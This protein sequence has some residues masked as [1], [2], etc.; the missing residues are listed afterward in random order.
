MKRKIKTSP[1]KRF[2]IGMG[3][4]AVVTFIT[5]TIAYFSSSHTFNNK[6]SSN[7]SVET[8]NL[9]DKDAAMNVWPG[10]T[11]DSNLIVKNTGD[12]PIFVRIKYQ[13]SNKLNDKGDKVDFSEKNLVSVD[14]SAIDG[15][16]SYIVQN[17]DKFLY[18]SEDGYYYY[19]GVL[20]SAQEIQHLDG[21]TFNNKVSSEVEQKAIPVEELAPS[22]LQSEDADINDDKNY[23]TGEDKGFGTKKLYS[24]TVV[25]SVYMGLRACVETVQA[26][27]ADG[28]PIE[29]AKVKDIEDT[30]EAGSIKSYWT[31]L[32]K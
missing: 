16:V 30:Q 27:N 24:G 3:A 7:Y 23:S 32:K 17:S 11:I 18:N 6:F 1:Q 22:Y 26:T 2:W 20:G 14:L 12:A 8:Y 15:S 19:K 29:D 5:A 31:E 13:R 25:P 9:V 10:E 28:T 21:I 4:C